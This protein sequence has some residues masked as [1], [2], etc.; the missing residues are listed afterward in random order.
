MATPA[1]DIEETS[2]PLLGRSVCHSC[3]HDEEPT[4]PSELD[5]TIADRV[6]RVLS[7]RR[8]LRAGE[9]SGSLGDLGTFLPDVVSLANNPH[10]AYPYP[11]AFTF[12]NGL[13]SLFSG[14]AYDLPLPIQP[15]HAVVAIALTEGLTY[16]QIVAS[17]VW[18]G[19]IFLVLGATGLVGALKRAI[20]LPVVR[21]LQLGLGLKVIG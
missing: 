9:V 16:A 18:L 19:L 2:Q 4:T 17:G 1:P 13:W 20:P 7:C 11:A 6:R 14:C 21:G 12:F 3:R 8:M 15:M 5:G 10:G